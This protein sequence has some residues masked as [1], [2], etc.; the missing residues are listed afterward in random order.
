M[1]G[2]ALARAPLRKRLGDGKKEHRG[3]PGQPPM[4]LVHLFDSPMD[5]RKPHEHIIT[6]PVERVVRARGRDRIEWKIRPLR[7]LCGE[8]SGH[9]RYVSVYFVDMHLAGRH[10]RLFHLKNLERI[11]IACTGK[12]RDLR[13]GTGSVS[14]PVNAFANRYSSPHQTACGYG[15][16]ILLIFWRCYK[17]IRQQ[18]ER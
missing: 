3:K 4:L 11:A 2:V 1:P 15:N 10:A 17:Q 7:K 16:A 18:Q 5:T 8:Q 13:Y 6:E 9:E 12:C 14:R